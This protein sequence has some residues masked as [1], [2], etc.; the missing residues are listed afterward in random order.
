MVRRKKSKASRLK[1]ENKTL[2]DDYKAKSRPRRTAPAKRAKSKGK[3]TA[4]RDE[5]KDELSLEP[6]AIRRI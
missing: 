6:R 4:L 3:Q 1:V 5:D 2:V